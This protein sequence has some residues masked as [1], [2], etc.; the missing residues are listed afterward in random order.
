MTQS[1]I[2]DTSGNPAD[3]KEFELSSGTAKKPFAT[4]KDVQAK[5]RACPFCGLVCRAVERYSRGKTES[6]ATLFLSWEVD[7]RQTTTGNER[8]INRTR[9]IRLSWREKDGKEEHV[10]LV[11]VAPTSA[12][13]PNSDAYAAQATQTH[14]LGRGRVDSTEK[15]A[16][17]KSWIDL[18]VKKHDSN[19]QK[20]H[21][22][23]AEF[24][25]LIEGTFFGVI[26]VTDMQLKALP[27]TDGEPARYVALSYV[28]GKRPMGEYTYTTTRVNVMVHIQHGGL[29][30]A[31]DQLPKTIQDTVLLVSRL[32]ERYV[33][34]DSLYIVQDSISSWELN[35]KSMHLVYGNAHFTI[36]AADGEATT[37]L[38]AVEPILRTVRPELPRTPVP[39][40]RV[41]FSDDTKPGEPPDGVTH[42]GPLSAQCSP[43]IRLLVSKPT[44]AVIQDSLWDSRVWVFQERLLSRRCLIFAEGQVYFQCRSAVMSQVS[45]PDNLYLDT[46]S[47]ILFQLSR[48]VF[49]TDNNRTFTQMEVP[50]AGHSTGQILRSG[51]WANFDAEHFGST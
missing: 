17:I 40:T 33:W 18:C 49:E 11:L 12:R 4:L 46:Q 27:V 45:I 14:F 8:L 38:R 2:T 23:R 31:W 50:M 35:A 34:I 26:D 39:V 24:K 32:G 36:C 7:G 28:W 41:K 16:L 10:Y 5:R 25:K 13:R 22:T 29:E 51:L 9:R 37:G 43:G 47:F 6:S 21:G 15:Q 42:S 1:V 19:C 48:Q 20:K 44:E 30:K 3:S